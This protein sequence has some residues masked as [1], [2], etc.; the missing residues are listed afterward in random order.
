MKLLEK[1]ILR[2][3]SLRR[4]SEDI[5]K[6]PLSPWDYHVFTFTDIDCLNYHVWAQET[7][8]ISL[9]LCNYSIIPSPK[10]VVYLDGW[11]DG[12]NDG[13]MDGWIITFQRKRVQLH[14]GVLISEKNVF[15]NPQSFQDI[16]TVLNLSVY[17]LNWN[18]KHKIN[19]VMLRN[20]PQWSLHGSIG[21]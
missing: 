7:N 12:W 17:P 19:F 20:N 15:T 14:M 21:I 10:V 16:Y 3:L 18:A 9:K 6:H 2:H 1:E 11:M 13:W 5:L 8:Q 4:V